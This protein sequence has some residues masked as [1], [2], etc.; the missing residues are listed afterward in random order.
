M[1]GNFARRISNSNDPSNLL[2]RTRRTPLI[3]WERKDLT[4]NVM[5]GE[6]A[7]AA[8]RSQRSESSL[9]SGDEWATS[10]ET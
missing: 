3:R 1:N 6:S 5:R 9:L 10:E 8:Q 2:K 4:R 7:G